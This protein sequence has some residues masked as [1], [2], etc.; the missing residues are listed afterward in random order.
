[1]S[2][3]KKVLIVYPDMII[4]GSTTAL[5]AFLRKIDYSAV[6]VDL[7][8][9][10][11]GD[12]RL[13]ELPPQVNVLRDAAKTDLLSALTRLRKICNFVFTGKMLAAL[14]Q[15]CKQK[16]RPFGAFFSA[17]VNQM[18]ARI[19]CE[20]SRELEQKYDLAISYL[21]LWP[22]VY[23]AEKVK[24]KEKVAWVHV[25]YPAARLN[26]ALDV[27]YYSKM[28]RIFCVSP[29][30]AENFKKCFPQ[31]QDRVSW[32]ENL[33]DEEGIR[34]KAELPEVLDAAFADYAG[35]RIVT[36]ARLDNYTKGLDRIASIT[37]KLKRDGL[38]FRWYLVG[39]GPGEAELT[40]QIAQSGIADRL[41]LLGAKNNPYPYMAGADLFVLAS[42]NEGKPV[43]VTEAQILHTPIL[44]TE[45]AAAAQQ[46]ANSGGIIVPNDEN[47]LYEKLKLVLQGKEKATKSKYIP[48]ENNCALKELGLQTGMG[49]RP[50]V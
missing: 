37:E 44:V 15:T 2:I 50:K 38:D 4:G 49:R 30:C 13:E 29:E 46:L 9:L 48:T 40:K 18:L 21:E 17:A 5:L 28:E 33:I 11:N 20:M 14:I 6:S 25:D 36:V 3:Q 12:Y 10:Q 27:Q 26:P 39:G 16:R 7:L 42:R 24:A 31:L 19:H 35:F 34:A 22:T 41:I 32:T 23:T 45:Y 47:V 43:T 1:M 8:L